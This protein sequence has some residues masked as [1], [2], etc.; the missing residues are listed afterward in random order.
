VCPNKKKIHILMD[1]DEQY[2]I[3]KKDIGSGTI[4]CVQIKKKY[5]TGSR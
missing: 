1:P 3:K 2:L 4:A 5:I